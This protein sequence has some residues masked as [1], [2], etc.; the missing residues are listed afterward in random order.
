ME[1]VQNEH[2]PSELVRLTQKQEG[3]KTYYIV[4]HPENSK[5]QIVMQMHFQEDDFPV[6]DILSF[7]IKYNND[8][9]EY[10]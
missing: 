4:F 5:L 9:K 10:Y 3:R 6:N 1:K 8:Y 7:F 2:R